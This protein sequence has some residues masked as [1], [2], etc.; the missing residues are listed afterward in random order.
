MKK[1]TILFV[2][3]GNR[4]RSRIAEEI[5]NKN[6]PKDFVARSAGIQYQ[7]YNDRATPIVLRELDIKMNMRKPQKVTKQMLDK[8]S[9]IIVFPG[10]S[11][12]KNADF[13]SVKDCHAGDI[14]CIRKGRKQ[15]EK[16]VKKLLTEIKP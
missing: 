9:R 13:W 16:H 15:I 6:A 3:R 14:S 12:S 1:K 8:A 7:R 4:F 11:I 5:F 2:C 10:V